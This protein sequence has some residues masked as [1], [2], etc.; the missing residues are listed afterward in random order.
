MPKE[1]HSNLVETD[2]RQ[3]IHPQGLGNTA[4]PQSSLVQTGSD[5]KAD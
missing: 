4:E 5:S 3:A 1:R 2:T